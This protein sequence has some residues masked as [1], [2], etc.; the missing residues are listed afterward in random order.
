MAEEQTADLLSMLMAEEPPKRGDMKDWGGMPEYVSKNRKALKTIDVQFK[1]GTSIHVHFEAGE[2]FVAFQRAIGKEID[3]WLRCYRLSNDVDRDAFAKLINQTVTEQTRYVWFPD[4]E[5]MSTSRLRYIENCR[6]AEQWNP[7]YPVY[8]ISKGRWETRLTTKALDRM[9]VP[10]R[11]VVEP[12]ELTRYQNVIDSDKIL[13]LP[14]ENYN[15][16]IR[17]EGGSIPARNFVW[18]HAVES[19]AERHW[20]LDDNIRGFYRLNR[21]KKVEVTTGAIF[22]AAEDFVDRYENVAIAGFNYYMFAKHR[23][24]LP[25][26][27]SNTRIYSC[28]LIKNDIDLRMPARGDI[29]MCTDRRWR[30][31]YNEDTDLSIRAM[32]LGYCTVL[33]YAFLCYKEATMTMKGGN[34]DELYQGD[35]RT[36]MAES[37]RA[38]HPDI[39]TRTWK[40]DRWQHLVDY[41]SFKNN[42]FKLKQEFIDNPPHGVNDYGMVLRETA[43]RNKPPKRTGSRG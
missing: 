43:K 20:I 15:K 23:D 1:D 33:F 6:A 9:N 28:I 21:N 2:N 10:Y 42:R 30:G 26:F 11:I 27:L 5:N 25:P 38:Q 22:R 34:T 41:D 12:Q 13:A 29:P 7:R 35:G 32:K 18:Q 16:S 4:V 19:G 36:K 24:K 37:L 17:G 3:P 39:A 8:I 14:C 31:R 40:S